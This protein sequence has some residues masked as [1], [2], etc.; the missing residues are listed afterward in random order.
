[1]WDII[2]TKT[3][4]LTHDRPC[5]YCGHAPHHYLPCDHDCGCSAGRDRERK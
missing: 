5:A 2:D 1:M 3:E 4:H